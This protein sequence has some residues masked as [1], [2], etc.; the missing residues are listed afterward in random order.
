MVPSYTD[1][2]HFRAPYKNSWP[3]TGI[4]GLGAE[5]PVGPPGGGPTIQPGTPEALA[6]FVEQDDKGRM[7]YKSEVAEVLLQNLEQARAVF[8]SDRAV[9]VQ[10]FSPEEIAAAA[11]SP[12]AAKQLA[13]QSGSAWVERKLGEGNIVFAT[14]SLVTPGA[15]DRQLAAV[16]KD[17]I[18]TVVMT[19]HIA[20]LLAEPSLLAKFGT[21]VGMAVAALGVGGLLYVI[22]KD[23][24]RTRL[25]AARY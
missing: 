16:P 11:S 2:S 8:L 7:R 1:V 3:Y 13:A 24:K 23:K 21:P 12:A 22:F 20:P 25:P 5:V 19:S 18:E 9:A 15:G 6:Q 14:L 10:S 17:E 4:N